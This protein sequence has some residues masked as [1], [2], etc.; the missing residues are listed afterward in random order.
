MNAIINLA[1]K[2]LRLLFRDRMGFFFTLVWPLGLAILFGTMYGGNRADQP[3]AVPVI[4]VDEDGSAESQAFVDSLIAAPEIEVSLAS[5]SEAIERVRKAKAVAF[6]ALKQGF[7]EASQNPFWGEPPAVEIGA[8]PSRG[9][10]TAMVEG[11][12]MKYA[13]RRI[14]DFFTDQ[15]AQREEL[16]RA[17]KELR[18]A[19]NIPER[20]RSNLENLF[21]SLEGVLSDESYLAS[22]T[23]ESEE[24]FSGFQPLTITRS[25]IS[26]RRR[27]PSSA[28][29]ISF[30]L[31]SMWALL[32]VSATFAVSIVHERT[33][34]TLFRL[35]AAPMTI[36]HILAGKALACFTAATVVVAGL[37]C[38]GYFAFGVV[39]N[40]ILLLAL[41]IVS[42]SI[43]FVGVMM[44]LS[45]LGK[46]EQSVGGASWGI[47]IIL[48]M[49]GGGMIPL[50]IM[51][52]W[53]R[54]LGTV[55]PIKW[56]ILA[57][58]G[59]VWRQFSP[60]EMLRP[61]LILIAIGAG[62]FL[63]GVHRK[64]T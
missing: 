53:M 61:C 17:R 12:L 22:D 62:S 13:S 45:T 25:E 59:A 9:P 7:G 49:F 50:F 48:S 36:Y 20:L 32:A 38:L 58:E 1:L 60:L 44:L 10:E 15:S 63:A 51:P 47:L 11:I 29:A 14:Q 3:R 19:E 55:S 26:I 31:G 37:F 21:A 28:Y 54:T 52:G 40:S 33:R 8:D 43:A 35:L 46:T 5:R 27:G 16:E 57:I 41:A 23:T 42:S 4:V 2:D 6:I 18:T 24:G 56:A 30:P 34:G 64:L 39:P